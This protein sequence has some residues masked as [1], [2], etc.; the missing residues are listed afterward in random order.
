MVELCDVT[1]A[2]YEYFEQRQLPP[3]PLPA[4]Q[5]LLQQ[6]GGQPNLFPPL[7]FYVKEH[8]SRISNIWWLL[9]IFLVFYF[10]DWHW[11]ECLGVAWWCWREVVWRLA[12]FGAIL[13]LGLK[14][15][16]ELCHSPQWGSTV[17][18]LVNRPMGRFA[19]TNHFYFQ[20]LHLCTNRGG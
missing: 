17:R 3:R 4:L 19:W 2:E 7:L 14:S 6:A 9:L 10:T 20:P 16:Q 13:W 5:P 18:T 12:C 8:F 1:D 11:D 15:A